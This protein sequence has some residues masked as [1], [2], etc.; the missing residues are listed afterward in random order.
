M[1]S[2]M[3]TCGHFTKLRD[4]QASV[5]YLNPPPLASLIF[6]LAPIYAQPVENVF[7]TRMLATQASENAVG[8][9]RNSRIVMMGYNEVI[10]LMSL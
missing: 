7:S 5:S 1:K 6:A 8:K 9:L 10:K 2:T 4:L 3:K